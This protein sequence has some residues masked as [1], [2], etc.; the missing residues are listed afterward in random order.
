MTVF[1]LRWKL[2]GKHVHVRVFAGT[3][4]SAGFAMCGELVFREGEW[5]S[6]VQCLDDTN[7]AKVVVLP[8]DGLP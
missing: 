1:R 8:E 3:A 7:T 4:D 2:L 5:P 6:F